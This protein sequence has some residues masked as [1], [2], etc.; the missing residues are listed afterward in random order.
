MTLNDAVSGYLAFLENERR[1]PKN[2]VSSYG[3]DFATLQRFATLRNDGVC[4]EL[5]ALDVFLLRSWLGHITRNHATSSVARM[6]AAVRGLLRWAHQRKL[7]ASNV[8][9]LIETPRVRRDLP[10]FLTVDAAKEVVETPSQSSPL[11]LRDR[12]VLELLYGS[13]LRVSELTAMDLA[14]VA[15]DDASARVTGKGDKQRVVPLGSKCIEAFV[16]YLKVRPQIV[17]SKTGDQDPKALFLSV[18]GLRL[19][20]RAVQTMVHAYGALGAGRADLHPHA[21][22]H[23]CATHMLTEGADLRAIQEL[24]GH[25]SVATTERYTHVSVEH[26]LRVYDASHPLAKKRPSDSEE[27]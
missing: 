11:A 16:A 10:T 21:L 13:G 7:V 20:V 12:A 22:R 27:P 26:I 15:L 9:E 25:A 24:L 2:T 3:F 17:N 19:G 14:D 18:R 8:A 23:T 1:A 5:D 4:P 6:L